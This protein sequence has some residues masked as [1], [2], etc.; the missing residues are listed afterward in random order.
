MATGGPLAGGPSLNPSSLVHLAL[1]FLQ[2]FTDITTDS[3]AEVA[4]RSAYEVVLRPKDAGS[5]IDSIVLDIDAAEHFPLRLAIMARGGGAPAV[6]VAFTDISFDRPD[7]SQFTFNPPPGVTM[8]EGT[9]PPSIG[10]KPPASSAEATEPSGN[11]AEK[12]ADGSDGAP[13]L[14]M[15]GSGWTMVVVTGVPAVPDSG[16]FA[17]LVTQLPKVSGNWGSGRLLSTRLFSALLTDDGR[18]LAGAV[19]PDRLYQAAKDPAARLD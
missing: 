6:E 8:E 9:T 5:L 18:L 17:D 1:T 19:S 10:T 4:G 16:P 15:L 11:P 3:S 2:P 7:A 14:K 13:R 12:P